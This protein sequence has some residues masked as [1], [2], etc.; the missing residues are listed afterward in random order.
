MQMHYPVVELNLFWLV[1]APEVALPE[2]P[3]RLNCR[4]HHLVLLTAK[5]MVL[6]CVCHGFL[7]L[8]CSFVGTFT[9]FCGLPA[10]R[11]CNL[12]QGLVL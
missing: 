5:E 1:L 4:H 8:W 11:F 10:R 6:G 9:G 7:P 12:S 2:V 3:A